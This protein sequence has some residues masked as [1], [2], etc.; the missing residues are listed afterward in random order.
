MIAKPIPKPRIVGLVVLVALWV[1]FAV[2]QR[3]EHVH[4]CRLIHATLSSQGDAL[5][6][7]VSNSIQS[8]RWF[9][10]FVR[11]QLPTTL[12]TLA[13]STNV[14]AIAVIA[15]GDAEQTYVAGDESLIASQLPAGEHVVDDTLQL[16]REF[17]MQNDPPMPGGFLVPMEP[18]GTKSFRSVVVLDRT[19]TMSQ[20]YLEARSRILIFVLGTLLLVAIG[21]VWQFTVRL[22]QSEGRTRLLTAETR[23]LRELGQA[24]A[25]LAHETRNPLGLIRG[26][27][28]RLVDAGLPGADQQ[29]QAEA[30]IEECDRVTAR[31]NQFL[32]FARQADLQIETLAIEDLVTE[33]NTLLQSDL[34]AKDLDLETVGLEAQP[35]Q[36][37]RDQLRQVLFNLLQN[38]IAFAPE[39]STIRLSMHRS[40]DDT[41]RIELADQGPGAC[42]QIADT[43]F[44]PYV[45]RRPGGTGLGLSIVRRIAAAH[46]WDVGY[47][48]GDEVGS[49]FWIDGIRSAS[50]ISN[51]HRTA[52]VKP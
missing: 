51:G 52:S 28:Q 30:V 13:R 41:F 29:Q 39:H 23:H 8:H 24:A 43:L 22:A 21:A 11:Q 50:N 48:S 20:F 32:A 34:D 33:L 40:P 45:T 12:D 31:I 27:T 36:A 37:D 15:G 1:M 10:P 9:S 46:Q 49:V 38:A 47:R 3:A 17:E 26:W 7:A 44:E 6:T 2:W 5:S 14:L 35:I 4:Q 19:E 16:V 18:A 42:E 25:G